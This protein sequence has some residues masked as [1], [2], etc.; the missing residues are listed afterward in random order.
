MRRLVELAAEMA[1]ALNYS[2]LLLIARPG[3]EHEANHRKFRSPVEQGKRED[4]QSSVPTFT[5]E[6]LFTRRLCT[7]VEG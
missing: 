2:H 6:V 7:H 5:P 3:I 4:K 1:A